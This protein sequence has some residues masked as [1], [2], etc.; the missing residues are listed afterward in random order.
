MIV[1]VALFQWKPGVTQEQ[2][3]SALEDV[4]ALKSKVPGLHDILCGANYSKWNDGLTHA[5]VVLAETQ[6]AL[7]AYR[8]HPDHVVVG[9]LIDGMEHRGI[10]VD[11]DSDN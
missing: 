5:V 3:S 7:D 11:F 1:H 10:G 2:V 4:R 6:E 8:R 9:K